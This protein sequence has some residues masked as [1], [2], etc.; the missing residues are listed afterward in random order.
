MTK[1]NIDRIPS[2]AE[3]DELMVQCSMLPNIVRHSIQVMNVSLA[4]SD[5]LKSH[6]Q[7]N[8]DLVLAAALLHDITK[9]KSLKTKEHHDTSG[10]EFL[11]SRGFLST[12]E[13]VEQ[14][15]MLRT[16]EPE[17][18]VGEREIV[19]YADKRVMHDT[20]VT[21]E[22]RMH[23]LIRRYGVTEEIRRQILRNKLQALSVERKIRS[24]MDVDLDHAVRE[25]ATG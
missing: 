13:I 10:G 21:L 11:R 20:I 25:M 22:E 1:R 24:L 4:I 2:R 17:G 6:V 9:T 3:C 23:D 15:I 8:R 14:H 16:F 7:V 5:N 19:Y 18:G 12:A